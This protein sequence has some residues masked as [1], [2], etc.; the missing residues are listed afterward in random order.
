MYSGESEMTVYLLS[1]RSRLWGFSCAE[2]EGGTH[3]YIFFCALIHLHWECHVV[4]RLLANLGII[5]LVRSDD[6]YVFEGNQNW[7]PIVAKM[8]VN[9]CSDQLDIMV[10]IMSSSIALFVWNILL[11]TRSSS[12]RI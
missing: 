11:Y 7:I 5:M 3:L 9:S 4:A 2:G 10:Q 6:L 8:P 1:S 12:P